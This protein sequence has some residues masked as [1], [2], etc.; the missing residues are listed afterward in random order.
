[1]S[2]NKPQILEG[3]RAIALT[4]KNIKPA[5]I[6]A[7]PITPQ[8]HIVEDLAKFKANG[9]ADYELLRAESEFAAASIVLGASASGVRTY[10]STSSQGL[11]LMAEVVY[12]IGGLQLPVVITCANRAVGAPINI[13]N[14][15]QDIMSVRDAGW[16]SFFAENHQEAV[17][18]HILAYKIAEEISIPAFVNVDGF[19]LTHSYGEVC[20]PEE[21]EIKKFLPDYKPKKNSYLDID[22][23]RTLGPLVTPADYQE[24]RLE[25]HK[26]IINSKKLIK[27]EWFKLKKI[28]DK[29]AGYQ[30]LTMDNGLVEYYGP[31][32]VKIIIISLGSVI[33]TIK[34]AVDEENKKSA[35]SRAKVG[36]IKIR[37]FRPFPDEE[38]LSIIKKTGAKRIITLE[39]S[40]SLGAK[41]I[42]ETEVKSSLCGKINI[43]VKGIVEGL[44]GK[45]I[46]KQMI[47]KILK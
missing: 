22:N 27:S 9:E 10:T 31:A 6:S 2:K 25:L 5:V 13:W 33:G 15:Q 21:K 45:D 4:V 20:I 47:K 34:D 44:G 46:T 11:L 41:G 16:L 30:L 14:D 3:S 40:I 32:K 26:K 23:P 38:I 35:V 29:N 1:M 17:Y 36:V 43:T 24:M 42:L 19:V 12:N 39:K 18:Q 37:T 28:F 8:T 7:Y